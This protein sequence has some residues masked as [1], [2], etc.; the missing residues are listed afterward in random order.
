[1]YNEFSD[2]LFSGIGC[3]EGMFSL[4][5]KDSS[6]PGTPPR[7]AYVLQELLMVK[8]DRLQKQQITV[9]LSMDESLKWCNSFFLVPKANGKVLIP[10]GP[11]QA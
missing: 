7:E 8:L 11:P 2:V 10:P 3:F 5:I 1:M 9:P 4:Q 6:W